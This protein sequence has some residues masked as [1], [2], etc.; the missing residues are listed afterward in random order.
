M[1]AKNVSLK[2]HQKNVSTSELGVYALY[3]CFVSIC[4][5]KKI[6][7]EAKK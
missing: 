2:I 4:F 6:E 1:K 7:V 3:G 5:S